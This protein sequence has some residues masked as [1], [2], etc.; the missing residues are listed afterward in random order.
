MKDNWRSNIPSPEKKNYPD[1]PEHA[2]QKVPM[3]SANLEYLLNHYSLKLRYNEVKKQIELEGNVDLGTI[4]NR[5]N[6]IDTIIC[7]VVAANHLANGN[8]GGCILRVAD[9]NSYNPVRDY[10]TAKPWD[11]MDRFADLAET[12]TVTEDY[13]EDLRNQLLRKWLRSAAAAAI[14]EG[15]FRARGVLTLQGPQGIGKTSWAAALVGNPSI[16]KCLKLGQ[17]LDVSNKDSVF[18]AISN[19]IVEIGELDST[20]KRDIGR[21]KGFLTL[22]GDKFRRPYAKAESTYPRRTVFMATVNEFAYLQDT[23]GNSRFWTVS[24]EE[25]DFNHD[26][27]MQQLWA[28]MAHEV[29]QGEKWWLD[30]DEEQQLASLNAKYIASSPVRDALTER[31]DLERK[32]E[33]GL[34]TMNATS[35]LQEVDIKYPTNQQCKEANAILRELLGPSRRINGVNKWSVPLKNHSSNDLTLSNV[36]KLESKDDIY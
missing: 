12:L 17:H 26:I 28:Q 29:N 24:V 30:D 16:K 22:D 33:M 11:G 35:I 32:N 25:I 27:D 6:V 3:T 8:L 13:P 4:E 31:I 23:T 34:P 20:F 15:D 21:L 5:D 14:N 36:K 9:S 7:D 18:G 10:I 2:N 19:W 1:Q